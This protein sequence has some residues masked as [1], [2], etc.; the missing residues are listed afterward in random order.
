[1]TLLLP[2]SRPAGF[3]AAIGVSIHRCA[4]LLAVGGGIGGFTAL[5]LYVT[6]T[7]Y[8]ALL[9]IGVTLILPALFIR[10]V[11]L[12]WFALFLL[13]LQFTISKNLNDGMA[14]LDRL[15]IDYTIENFTFF[16]NGSDVVLLVMLVLWANDVMFHGKTLRFPRVTW[17][18]VA[19]IGIGI[20]SAVGAPSPYLGMVD[21]SRQ[22]RYLIVFL[23]A[24]NCL[25]TKDAL[26]TLV[27]VGVVILVTQAAVTTLRFE[28][29]YMTPL[30]F[31]ES[32]QDVEQIKR[33]LAVDR[34]EEGSAIR[35]FGTL[36]SPGTMLRL[37]LLVIPFALLLCARNPMFRMRWLFAS[38]TALGL[39]GLLLTF[40]RVYYITTSFQ[41][42][43][44][45]LI[46]IR[47]RMLKREEVVLLVLLAMAGLV[48]VTPKLYGQF[49]VR[50]DSVSVRFLQYEAAMRMIL[51]HPFL[52]V[53]L[54]NGIGEKQ[55][56]NQLTFHEQDPNTQFDKEQTHDMYLNMAS[57]IGVV[58]TLLF[59]AFFARV[60]L[61]AWRQS[62]HASDP[63]VKWAANA[64]FVTFCSVALNAVM[65]PFNEYPVLTLLW[66]EAGITLNLARMGQPSRPAIHHAPGDAPLGPLA[67]EG[68]R[69]DSTIVSPTASHPC[70]VPGAKIT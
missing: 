64:L 15:K 19:Y 56:Y 60:A 31:G 22:V 29:G 48:A 13:S 59:C 5:A 70:V 66:L 52:G 32:H 2:S 28:T 1:M 65:D 17:L 23:F 24:V 57:E 34:T 55:K 41:I 54:N 16:I 61:V 42:V 47:D 8:V 43:L 36:G 50:E 53:G 9:P 68:K 10:N 37:C 4:L 18:A 63:A 12:Y 35:A 39:L 67:R 58:G 21:V 14:V 45:F 49:T 6:K 26:R 33:Y 27:V 62:R 3:W 44:V 38:L 40:T 7:A 20:V 30:V 51:D 46:M 69:T 25:D 11:R